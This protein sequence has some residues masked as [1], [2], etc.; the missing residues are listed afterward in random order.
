MI[1]RR[2]LDAVAFSIASGKEAN[3]GQESP[4][5]PAYRFEG[6]SALN[7]TRCMQTAMFYSHVVTN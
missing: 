2:S 1:P 5:L 7:P 3:A 6:S 4:I